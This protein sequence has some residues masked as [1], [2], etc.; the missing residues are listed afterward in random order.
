MLFYRTK[1]LLTVMDLARKNP[2][3]LRKKS[4]LYLWKI[5]S[6]AVF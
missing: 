5:L 1:T 6:F 3:I 2:Q 4:Q